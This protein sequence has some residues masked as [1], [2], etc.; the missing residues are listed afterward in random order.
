[1]ARS[2]QRR[3]SSRSEQEWAFKALRLQQW[4]S[5]GTTAIRVAGV[6]AC[7]YFMYLMVA[8]LA[9]EVTLADVGIDFL[10][11]FRVNTA[12]AWIFGA[13]GT[14]YGMR[15]RKL[16]RD[17]VER[18][19]ARPRLVE[20]RVGTNGRGGPGLGRQLNCTRAAAVLAAS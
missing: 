4:V 18:L 1:M 7:F 12:V 3:P 10:A 16:R 14:V 11:D 9:G 6:V 17:T 8:S 20:F 2:S 15:Q 13:G 5:V 19:M